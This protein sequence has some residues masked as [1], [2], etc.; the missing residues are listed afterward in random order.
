M[1]IRPLFLICLQL[2]LRKLYL[3]HKKII[4]NDWPYQQVVGVSIGLPLEPSG[5]NVFLSIKDKIWL[6]QCPIQSKP[7]YCRSYLYD[8][9]AVFSGA[10]YAQLFLDYLTTNIMIL[11]VTIE[12]Q[13]HNILLS[14]HKNKCYNNKMKKTYIENLLSLDGGL[15][16]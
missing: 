5:A 10:S 12:L 13:G 1:K 3:T 9:F 15:D 14:R 6:N 8:I 16:F 11:H 4:F 2:N 7:L